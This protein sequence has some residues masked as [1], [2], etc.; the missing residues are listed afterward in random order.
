MKTRHALS[1]SLR[2][3][4]VRE[5]VL[6]G[7]AAGLLIAALKFM[8]GRF[9]LSEVPFAFYGGLVAFLSAGVGIW[10]G[11]SLRH[12]DESTSGGNMAAEVTGSAPFVRDEKRVAHLGLTP[13]E[14]E[15]LELI[16]A[17]LSNRGIAE[18]LCVSVNTVKTH[19]SRVFGKLG[20]KRRTQA[21]QIGREN[22]LIP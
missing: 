2:T 21:V 9:L 15:I 20:A 19:A 5:V 8:E 12:E 1:R 6:Y 16:A 13:R 10:L 7:L 14:L 22:G 11:V 18:R 3:S 4:A 17:G